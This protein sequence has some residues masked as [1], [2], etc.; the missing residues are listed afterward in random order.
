MKKAFTLAEIMIVLSVIAVLTAILLPA[1]KNATP[2][3]DLMK[4]KKGHNVLLSAIRELVNSDKYYY[5]G[6]L[7]VKQDGSLVDS[8]KF[9]CNSL[10][11]ILSVK[12]VNCS[13][14]NLGYNTTAVANLPDFTTYEIDGKK[15]QDLADCMCKNN[16]SAGEEI[17]LSD[18]T[19]IYSV[20]PYYH[21]GAKTES[22][23]SFEGRIFNPCSQEQ[24]Y[25]YICLD[26]DG[27]NSGEEPFGYALRADGKIINGSRANSWINRNIQSKENE[28]TEVISSV[29]SCPSNSL[30][31]TPENDTCSERAGL[32]CGEY[33]MEINLADKRLCMTKYNVGDA[34]GLT[35]PTTVTVVEAGGGTNC[36]SSETRFCC[37]S[38]ETGGACDSV[39]G[40]YSGCFRTLCD[41]RAANESC[42]KLTYLGKTWRL[43]TNDELSAL[44]SQIDTV[45][46]GVGNSG[47]MLCE[48]S[49]NYNSSQCN[50]NSNCLGGYTTACQAYYLW[51]GTL[52]DS[53]HAYRYMILSGSWSQ[54]S[55]QF[56]RAHSVRCVAEI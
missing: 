7:G 31:I 49:R 53:L 44:A 38:G 39:N 52:V 8:P 17:V 26:I 16:L 19:V 12:A 48:Q 37:W 5:D 50:G 22:G 11:D 40:D 36:V 6:D 23:K 15:I 24:R 18:G 13:E 25:K 9:F 1:A 55:Y 45:S 34:P 21:F 20:N 56:G 29:D 46:I 27:S 51:S 33:A 2:N 35:I 28:E 43:P 54:G 47:L 32:I 14:D 10:A 30:D 4:F 41:W 42:S 3:E